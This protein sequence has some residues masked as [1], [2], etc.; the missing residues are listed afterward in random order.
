[1]DNLNRFLSVCENDVALAVEAAKQYEEEVIN[2]LFKFLSHFMQPIFSH[3]FPIQVEAWRQ[4]FE[5]APEPAAKV[6][7]PEKEKLKKFKCEMCDFRAMTA[8]GVKKHLNKQHPWKE[9]GVD[10]QNATSLTKST[11]NALKMCKSHTNKTLLIFF[12][13]IYAFIFLLNLIEC[14]IL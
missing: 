2:S 6:V 11:R 13:L 12:V 14:I 10:D 1:M 8:L 3:N 9:R 4:E 5:K 7:D